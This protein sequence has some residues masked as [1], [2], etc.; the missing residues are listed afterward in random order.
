MIFKPPCKLL[1]LVVV[2]LILLGVSLTPQ[3]SPTAQAQGG[4]TLVYGSLAV[5]SI[6]A[7]APVQLYNF[8]GTQGDL[9][10]IHMRTL[11]N[12]LRPFVDLLAPDRQVIASAHQDTLSPDTRDVQITLLL[13]VTGVFSLMIGGL[14][15]TTGD[16]LL[17][18]NGRGLTNRVPLAPGQPLR[19]TIG[20]NAP[21]QYYA[22]STETCATTLSI[23]S[24]DTGIPYTF[25]FVVTVR[26]ERGEVV[27][28][29]RGG[30]A[31]ED[32]VTVAQQSGT[33]EVEVWADS[34]ALTGSLTLLVTCGDEPQQCLD[35]DLVVGGGPGDG[36]DVDCPDCPPCPGD[37]PDD[38]PLCG[39]FGISVDAQDGYTVT[40]S[41][42]AVEGANAAII[43]ANDDLGGLVYARMVVDTLTDT[44]DVPG[45]GIYTIRVAVGAEDA[46]YSLCVDTIAIEVEGEGPVH[47]GDDDDECEVA[48]V[49]PLD[50]IANGLQTFFW[51]D[52]PGAESYRLRIYGQFDSVVAEGVI[53]APATSLT[54]DVSLAAIGVG[55]GGGNDFYAQLDVMR[56]GE[57][58]CV[59]GQRVTRTP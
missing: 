41:W 8:S 13:P 40:I 30:D 58:W 22:F 39:A 33:Y 53:S 3:A 11:S 57:R 56:G 54:M 15:G 59:T 45:G 6:S 7:Q 24:P 27:S 20:R 12:G 31:L 1:S 28:V 47:W 18:L 29:L 26:D 25:P 48:F 23:L 4:G 17:E 55:Y 38:D 44:F 10:E 32:R 52:V 5:G 42:S 2:A 35:N 9:V 14:D 34:P 49:A 51:T 43:S 21:P 16:Y 37:S 19:V 50:T 46:G 36:G